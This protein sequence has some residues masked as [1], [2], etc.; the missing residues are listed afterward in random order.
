MRLCYSITKMANKEAD[1]Q[2]KIQRRGL[3]ARKRQS[4]FIADY[5]STKYKDIYNEAAQLFNQLNAKYP[6]RPNLLK[7]IEY[8]NWQNQIRGLPEV[9]DYKNWQCMKH[10]FYQSIPLNINHHTV[11]E[12]DA[13]IQQCT[14]RVM[15]LEIPLLDIPKDKGQGEGETTSH[16]QS[17]G[18]GE[19]T[20]HQQSNGEGETTS[21]QQ[22]MEIGQVNEEVVDEG[23]ANQD[24]LSDIQPSLLDMLPE[25]MLDE[26]ISQIQSEPSLEAIMRDF[27]TDVC[28][29][30]E[31]ENERKLEADNERE[32]NDIFW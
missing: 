25:G 12:N 10:D 29:N 13:I 32:L 3:T 28:M 9:R 15:R 23:N 5:V 24:D 27:D 6:R 2:K 20:S 1:F 18:E 11:E 22:P 16:Q 8:K 14:Q 26:I 19:T 7:C 17:N 21:H 4:I 31:I 30:V